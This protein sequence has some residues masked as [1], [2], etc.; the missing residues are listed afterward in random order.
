MELAVDD[1]C[2]ESGNIG[3]RNGGVVGAAVRGLRIETNSRV[4]CDHRRELV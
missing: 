4:H 3:G 1:A 2:F